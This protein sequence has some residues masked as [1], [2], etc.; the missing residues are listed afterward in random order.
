MERRFGRREDPHSAA[1]AF[2]LA[3]RANDP[4]ADEPGRLPDISSLQASGVYP[5]SPRRAIA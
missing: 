4:A 5:E 1:F 2:D 3:V